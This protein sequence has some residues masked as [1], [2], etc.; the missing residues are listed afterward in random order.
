MSGESYVDCNDL[1][2]TPRGENVDVD[3][4]YMHVELLWRTSKMVGGGADVILL[5]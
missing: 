1:L 5:L 3:M 2:P 4:T